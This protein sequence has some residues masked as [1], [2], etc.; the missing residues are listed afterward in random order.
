MPET[1][2]RFENDVTPEISL[3]LKER[4]IAFRAGHLGETLPD[5]PKPTSGR[6]GDILKPLQQIIRLVK[7]EREPHFL[8]LVRE[9]ESD[10]LIEK[11]DSIE[12]QILMVL[13]GLKD[14]VERGILPVKTITDAFNE[15]KS[16]KYK[17]TYQRVGRR[18]SAM[19]F[20]K[21]RAHDG[22]SAIIWND[23][24]IERMK[25]TYGLQKTSETSDRSVTSDPQ[26]DVTGVSDDTDVSRRL[27]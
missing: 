8:Q 2:K 3:P 4:L 26:P 14:E 21:C 10:R 15:E 18:L 1:K 5:I 22:A 9:L 13:I 12:A 25:E 23:E 11:G 17:V 7:P 6:L 20:K 16:D 24:S 19:G 27:F